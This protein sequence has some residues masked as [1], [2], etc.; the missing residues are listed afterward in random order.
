MTYSDIENEK[1][2]NIYYII[3]KYYLMYIQEHLNSLKE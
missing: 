2:V 1:Y 3:L